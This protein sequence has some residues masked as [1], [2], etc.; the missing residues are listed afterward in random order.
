[1]R[2]LNQF[3]NNPHAQRITKY[4]LASFTFKICRFPLCILDILNLFAH[5]LVNFNTHFDP[6]LINQLSRD[7]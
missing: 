2:L 3:T 5:Q 7:I 4:G 6:K 1:M